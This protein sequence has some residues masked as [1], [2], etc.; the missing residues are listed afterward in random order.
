MVLESEKALKHIE[1]LHGYCS[2]GL[3]LLI[4]FG[5]SSQEFTEH[6]TSCNPCTDALIR[7]QK[8]MTREMRKAERKGEI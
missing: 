3:D 2:T 6:L 8:A 4:D 5:P 7:E 1:N